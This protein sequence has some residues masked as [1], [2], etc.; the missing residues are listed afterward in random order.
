[1]NCVK[2]GAVVPDEHAKKCEYCGGLFPKTGGGN[3]PKTVQPVS[4][5]PKPLPK[6]KHIIPIVF[7]VFI[8]IA[9]TTALIIYLM[10]SSG[11]S[12][13]G[14]VAV[15]II[16]LVVVAIIAVILIIQDANSSGSPVAK[17]MD[18]SRVNTFSHKNIKV[19]DGPV[20]IITETKS[21]YNS[22]SIT[23]SFKNTNR[24]TVRS[25]YMTISLFSAAG[26]VIDDL[27]INKKDIEPDE[28]V[29]FAETERVYVSQGIPFKAEVTCVK[30]FD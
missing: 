17:H 12:N 3:A 30:V 14:G 4:E 19:V 2:C 9:A 21:D 23:G 1:M 11:S 25:L 18:S 6:K 26:A 10:N 15:F 5:A 22:V 27:R 24:K 7:L 28:V 16:M 20:M 29:K 8:F 13:S